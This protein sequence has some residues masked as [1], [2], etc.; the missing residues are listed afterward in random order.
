[1]FLSS[2]SPLFAMDHYHDVKMNTGQTIVERLEKSK[3]PYFGKVVPAPSPDSPSGQLLW[4][5]FIRI[6]DPIVK[7][8]GLK[9][10]DLLFF[11]NDEEGSISLLDENSFEEYLNPATYEE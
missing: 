3:M 7:K 11:K 1:M 4:Q 6:P 9:Q 2:H 8:A 10:G 5:N